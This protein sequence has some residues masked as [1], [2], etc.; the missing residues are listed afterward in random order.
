MGV[1]YSSETDGSADGDALLLYK[2][3][4]RLPFD[5][6]QRLVLAYHEHVMLPILDEDAVRSLFS[7]ALRSYVAEDPTRATFLDDLLE[8]VWVLFSDSSSCYA[9]E[10]LAVIVLLCSAPWNKRLSLIFDVFKCHA[11]EELYYEDIILASQV[12]AQGLL[13]LWRAPPWSIDDLR[14]LTESI[15]DH[16]FLKM[17]KDL[18]EPVV[19]EAFISWSLDRFRESRT[20]AT[21]DA[22]RK[23]YETTFT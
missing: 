5:L 18:A 12:V 2:E 19:R 7:V 3:R 17:V 11:I 14:T 21:S 4:L 20:V 10:I 1:T 9:Q 8:A 23:I 22:L 16:A 6:A 13:R 15:A